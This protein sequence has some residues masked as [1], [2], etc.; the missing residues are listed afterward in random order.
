MRMKDPKHLRFVGTCPC[1]ICKDDTSTEAAHVRFGYRPIAKPITGMGIK[2]DDCYTV[3]LCGKHHREQHQGDEKQFWLRY[4]VMAGEVIQM[5]LALFAHTG[6][7]ERG[8][9]IISRSAALADR[10]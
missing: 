5:A 10:S 7:Y 2:P 8:L 6:D 9:E 3:P 1:A 4:G